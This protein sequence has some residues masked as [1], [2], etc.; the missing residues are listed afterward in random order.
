MRHKS[1]KKRIDNLLLFW[2]SFELE[3]VRPK[4]QWTYY[5][6]LAFGGLF[7]RCHPNLDFLSVA[8]QTK[9]QVDDDDDDVCWGVDQRNSIMTR[10]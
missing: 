10:L 6:N 3:T 7:K 9:S 2:K 5:P 8:R 1:I 4:P